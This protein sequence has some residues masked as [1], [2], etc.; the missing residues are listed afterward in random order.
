MSYARLAGGLAMAVLTFLA[1]RT[2][3][4]EPVTI[5]QV[6]MEPTLVGGDTALVAKWCRWATGWSAGDVV[7]LR[8]PEDGALVVKR[9][10][11]TGGQR[12]GLRDGRLAVDGRVAPPDAVSDALDGVYFGPV[13]VPPRTVFVMGDN[14]ARSVD[15]RAFGPVEE[16]SI[17]GCVV[18]VVWPPRHAGPLEALR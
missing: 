8:A 12:V 9:I 6:S 3:L 15:S 4:V 2:A 14:R 10:V 13:L 7:A 1:V 17:T 5:R 18:G 16:D 11:A